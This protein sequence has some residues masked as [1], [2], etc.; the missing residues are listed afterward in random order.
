MSRILLILSVATLVGG[1]LA[2][3]AGSL[4]QEVPAAALSKSNPFDGDESASRAGAKLFA[5]E[6][7]ACHGRV[8]EGI[9]KAPALRSAEVAS[10]PA[11]SLFW[12]LRNGSLY[13]GM[14]SF[15]HLPEP[16]R[17]QIVTFLRT[18]QSNPAE[19]RSSV[20]SQINQIGRR[21]RV[22]AQPAGANQ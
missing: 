4:I 11:A 9:G 12:I 15:A 14:P 1:T 16:G 22:T 21:R 17:W 6:C 19:V 20:D 13:R 5:H 2:G 10:A 8:G 18:L 7:S 3:Q